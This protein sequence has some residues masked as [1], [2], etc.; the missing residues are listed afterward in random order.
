VQVT[1]EAPVLQ[2][3]SIARSPPGYGM[4]KR[5][6]TAVVVATLRASVLSP[7]DQKLMR[8]FAAVS[9]VGWGATGVAGTVVAGERAACGVV[10]V[11]GVVGDDVFCERDE[12]A[13]KR[14]NPPVTAPTQPQVSAR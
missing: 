6:L 1:G 5:L 13:A 14:N 10:V 11:E 8:A 9:A 2:P 3:R 12:Q 7:E 4:A